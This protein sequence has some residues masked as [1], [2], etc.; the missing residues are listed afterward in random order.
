MLLVGTQSTECRDPSLDVT[1]NRNVAE[2][3]WGPCYDA[4][5]LSGALSLLPISFGDPVIIALFLRGPCHDG[6]K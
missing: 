6:L 1:Q 4:P 2:N 3:K 5:F